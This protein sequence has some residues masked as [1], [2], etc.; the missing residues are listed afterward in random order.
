LKLIDKSF[1]SDKIYVV[2]ENGLSGPFPTSK[3]L[4]LAQ[5]ENMDLI[6][7]S[8]DNDKDI[9]IIDDYGRR[10]FQKEKN[11]KQN[12]RKRKTIQI[13]ERIHNND[14]RV[15]IN[16]IRGFLQKNYYVNIEI[17]W[18]KR[19]GKTQNSEVILNSIQDIFIEFSTKYKV[20]N[21]TNK[22]I[23]SSI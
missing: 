22:I 18:S 13:D 5:Y 16:H 12:T 19:L 1:V 4:S 20:D 2:G 9:C 10:K 8:S 17:T 15:K 14:L 3:A 6:L 23:V 11:N 7:L 21:N